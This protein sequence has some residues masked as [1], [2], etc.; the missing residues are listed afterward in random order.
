MSE[1]SVKVE[2]AH[3]ALRHHE[4]D[5]A[6]A[7][8]LAVGDSG[9][10]TADDSYGLAT[11]D[12]WLGLMQDALSAYEQAYLGYLG[13]QRRDRAALAAFDIAGSLFLRGDH[14]RGSGWLSRFNRL[15]QDMPEGV[16]H[17]YARWVELDG[18]SADLHFDEA[19]AA[20][21]RLHADGVLYAD[22]DLC[23]LALMLEGR[24]LVRHGRVDA[25]M[26]VL[27][28]AMLTAAS[29]RMDPAYAG[30]V[31]CNLVAAC[32]EVLDIGRMREW[33]VALARWC[34]SLPSAVLFTG[35]CRVH[36]AQL[37]QL[38]GD[39]DRAEREAAKVCAELTDV[40]VSSVAEA[41]YVIGEIRLLRGDLTGAEEQLGRAD[42]LGRDPQPALALVRLAQ[43]DI[44]GAAAM[45][46][47]A[48]AVVAGRPT[49][50]ARLLAAQVEI[51]VAAGDLD[52]ADRAAEELE[53]IAAAYSTAGLR[54]MAAQAR[55]AVLVARGAAT[56]ALPIL[57]T[58]L[59]TWQ[60]LGAPHPAARVRL[61][62]ARAQT[63]LG[64]VTGALNALEAAA[65]VFTRLGA[66]SDA[67]LASSL[68]PSRPQP[69][70]L[71]EREAQI[72]VLV[73]AGRT[74]PQI[75]QDLSISHKTVA[76]HL[77]NIFTKC[78]LA[79][80]TAAAAYVFEH[81]MND[82]NARNP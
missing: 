75:G 34:E 2:A 47:T 65:E 38:G 73:A 16:L 53:Q 55:G 12:W 67:R 18:R 64:D 54:G 9:Q 13:D 58:A 40:Q 5:H 39:W 78:G 17:S 35:I 6:R 79:T 21:R 22:L 33:T 62:V 31:Y 20:A 68:R 29:G 49:A 26:S 42:K 60:E 25:G 46:G 32:H 50:R 63:G 36:R 7:L 43:R 48:L 3:D 52:R 4:W 44:A 37:L 14:V 10:L 72:L 56:Q 27:D 80:R 66:V 57:H 81:G 61:L 1:E 41:H 15:L 11:A 74:N 23:T 19:L 28:E 51:T 71:T 77:S 24:I 76:R 8:F 69:D 82:N 30:N 45:I 70:G 59:R